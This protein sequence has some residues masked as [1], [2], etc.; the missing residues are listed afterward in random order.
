ML[1]L[2]IGRRF[3]DPGTFQVVTEE[4]IN[5]SQPTV[6]R[7]VD[8]SWRLLSSTLLSELVQFPAGAADYNYFYR[9]G[10][11]PGVTGIID[12]P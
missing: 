12:C 1:L 5:P 2:L 6:S 9:T 10:N 3:S 8:R 4:L 7:V 11:F